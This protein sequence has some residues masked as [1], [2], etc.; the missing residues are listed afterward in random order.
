MLLLAR[1][2]LDVDP[3]FAEAERMC[4]QVRVHG[5]V[6]MGIPVG[7]DAFI[8]GQL[9][10]M[11]EKQIEELEAVKYFLHHSLLLSLLITFSYFN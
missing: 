5:G 3:V 11:M 9:E 4:V 8:E 2:S 1:E 6:V 10:T 7:T